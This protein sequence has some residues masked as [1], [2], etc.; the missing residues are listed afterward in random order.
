MRKSIAIAWVVIS[1][2]ASAAAAQFIDGSLTTRYRDR[3]GTDTWED[4]DVYVYLRMSIWDDEQARELGGAFSLRW[5]KDLLT[6]A[7]EIDDG[8]AETRVYYAY[9]DVNKLEDLH[10]RLGRQILDEAEGF[11]LTGLKAIYDVGW[12][13]L[14]IG[15]FGGQPVSYYK[16]VGD[17]WAAGA[18]FSLKPDRLSQLRG[19]WLHVEEE[20]TDDDVATLS[21]R[22]SSAAGWNLWGTVRTLNFDVWNES[23]G[24][25][26]RVEPIDLIV[27]GNYR[28]QEDTN[29]ST[30]RYYYGHLSTI[31]GPSLP[32]HRLTVSLTR[33]FGDLFSL[34][35]SGTRRELLDDSENRG[36]QEYTRY[37]F[38][39]YLFERAL[40]G[41]EATLDYSRWYTDRDDNDTIGG[42]ISR[43]IGEKLRFDLGTYYAKYE[44]HRFFDDP[45]EL[46]TERTDVRSYYLRGD[47]KVKGRYR[48]QLELERGTDS[49]SDDAYYQVEARFGLDLG[50]LG[51]DS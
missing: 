27:T 26:Y 40:A 46:P 12:K 32:Y 36:N 21:Y 35:A 31:L 42:S 38:D 11:H 30:S 16:S 49:T 9:V 3:W 10:L 7:N 25:T 47:W 18:S 37:A 34:G 14:R 43:R 22:R 23:L 2:V 4:Q 28:R 29:A 50:F 48:V 19:S 5:D 13:Q 1:L 24:G 17:D 41:F 20:L 44:I 6:R 51:R 33:P 15:A 8:D 39:V 45:D